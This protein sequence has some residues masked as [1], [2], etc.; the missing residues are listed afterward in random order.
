MF[1]FKWRIFS[2]TSSEQSGKNLTFSNTK[3]ELASI[4]YLL[5]RLILKKM[6]KYKLSPST[7]WFDLVVRGV[8]VPT[9]G[10]LGMIFN[11]MIIIV[12][13]K[14]EFTKFSINLIMLC[15]LTEFLVLIIKV[16]QLIMYFFV[17]SI[18]WI[19]HLYFKFAKTSLSVSNH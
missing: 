8:L 9:L 7:E 3:L 11:I 4:W 2:R 1:T 14:P 17:I 5:Y 19:T 15:K 12:L 10:C 13:Q 6:E 16:H 18:I